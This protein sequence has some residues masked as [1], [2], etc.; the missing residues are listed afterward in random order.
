MYNTFV[1][2]PTSKHN[3][4]PNTKVVLAVVL[5]VSSLKQAQNS[6]NSRHLSSKKQ[7][8]TSTLDNKI[9]NYLEDLK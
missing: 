8:L 9:Y 7:G 4:S 3:T 1:P 5:K 2:F 6:S